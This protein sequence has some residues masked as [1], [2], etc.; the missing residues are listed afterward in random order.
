[1]NSDLK[2]LLELLKSHDVRFLVIGSHLLA[3]YARPRFTED[4]VLW[5][6]RTSENALRLA[7]A[8]REFGFPYPDKDALNLVSGRNML[9]LG[10]PPNRV[11]FLA[12]LGPVDAEMSF[13]EADSRATES[14]LMEVRLR[15]LSKPDFIASKRAAGRRKDLLDLAILEEAEE[16]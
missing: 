16:S 7:A 6:E 9:R 4:L 5:I 13:V 10:E 15:F 11:D 3:L 1:M 14:E 2:E 8:L 12:F